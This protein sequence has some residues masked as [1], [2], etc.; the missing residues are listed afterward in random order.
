MR[1]IFS[2]F[3]FRCSNQNFSFL[4]FFNWT[5]HS[6]KT[7]EKN[8]SIS[9]RSAVVRRDLNGWI[10]RHVRVHLYVWWQR[11]S[12]SPERDKAKKRFCSSSTSWPKKMFCSV[13][14]KLRFILHISTFKSHGKRS[15][16]IWLL[17]MCA[18]FTHF[19]SVDQFIG[20]TFGDGFHWFEGRISGA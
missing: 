15:L 3:F 9:E 16:V 4:F 10:W 1:Q 12:M 18:F 13:K 20:K 6:R 11:T 5:T 19:R 17:M 2:F 14:K 8:A 7:R